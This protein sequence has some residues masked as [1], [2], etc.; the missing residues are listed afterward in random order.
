MRFRNLNWK[1]CQRQGS[2]RLIFGV[3]FLVFFDRRY[4]GLVLD[5]KLGWQASASNEENFDADWLPYLISHL[6]LMIT[7]ALDNGLY[8]DVI[9]D[10]LF[11]FEQ[12]VDQVH[13]DWTAR[14]CAAVDRTHFVMERPAAVTANLDSLEQTAPNVSL[15][16]LL[17]M[18]CVLTTENCRCFFLKRHKVIKWSFQDRLLCLYNRWTRSL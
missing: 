8:D 7:R 4:F 16:S 15:S 18:C 5:D 14:K 17:A 1:Q 13:L 11:V 3:S 10:Y 2:L 9:G 6:L 12:L